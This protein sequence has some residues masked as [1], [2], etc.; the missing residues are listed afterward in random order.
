MFAHLL[1]AMP[2]FCGHHLRT[3]ACIHFHCESLFVFAYFFP[4]RAHNITAGE[5]RSQFRCISFFFRRPIKSFGFHWTFA[6]RCILD[7]G[8]KTCNNK[9]VGWNYFWKSGFFRVFLL[10]FFAAVIIADGKWSS[11]GKWSSDQLRRAWGQPT[12]HE[13]ASRH[14]NRPNTF[15]RNN[16][17][18]GIDVER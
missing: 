13:G 12:T 2:L 11:S 9:S 7:I 1:S 5:P 3:F 6:L 8:D 15:R 10:H 18:R 14:P 17:R 16:A 4:F